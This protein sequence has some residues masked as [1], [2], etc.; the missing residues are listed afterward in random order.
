MLE[1]NEL[2]RK[3]TRRVSERMRGGSENE[4]THSSLHLGKVSIEESRPVSESLSGS[5]EG[6][7]S[8]EVC[9][10]DATESKKV[11]VEKASEG[12]SV[13]RTLRVEEEIGSSRDSRPLRER[14]QESEEEWSVEQGGRKE[15]TEDRNAPSQESSSSEQR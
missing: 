15:A 14:Q 11:S 12:G 7:L 2:E 10:R 8:V 13:E 4:S 5:E 9:G 1:G 6:G 3:R